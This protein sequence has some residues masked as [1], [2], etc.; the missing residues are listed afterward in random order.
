MCV[1]SSPTSPVARPDQARGSTS[2]LA[3]LTAAGIPH[4]VLTYTVDHVRPGQ[5][6]GPAVAQALG[7]DPAQLFKTLVLQGPAGQ[8]GTAVVPVTGGLDLKAS[9]QAFGWKKASLAPPDLAE[10]RTGSVVGGISPLGHRHRSPVVVDSSALELAELDEP[11]VVSA[12]QRGLSL[13][14]RPEDLIR[15]AEARVAALRAL[16]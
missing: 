14:L 13:R 7:I 6:Y 5:G 10:R 1:N 8:V 12:G 2:A 11:L 16:G 9:A 15:V 4:E 3:V